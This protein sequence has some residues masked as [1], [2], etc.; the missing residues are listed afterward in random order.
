MVP[1]AREI[2]FNPSPSTFSLPIPN[3]QTGLRTCFLMATEGD[4]PDPPKLPDYVLDPNAVLGDNNAT[5]RYGKAPDYSRT[6]SVWA[7]STAPALFKS[8]LAWYDS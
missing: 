8:C 4:S 7:E 3:S 5:W 6:R 2:I 1:S